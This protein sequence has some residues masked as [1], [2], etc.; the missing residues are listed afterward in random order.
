MALNEKNKKVSKG[1]AGISVMV[2]NASAIVAAAESQPWQGHSGKA[3]GGSKPYDRNVWPDS[4]LTHEKS[5]AARIHAVISFCSWSFFAVVFIFA[6]GLLYKDKKTDQSLPSTAISAANRGQAPA[7]PAYSQPQTQRQPQTPA[8]RGQEWTLD[9]T[10]PPAGDGQRM[11]TRTEITY[12][13]A[14]EIR[15]EAAAKLIDATKSK[16]V[17]IYNSMIADLNDSCGSFRYRKSDMDSATGLVVIF[18]SDL[19]EQGRMIARNI[20][21]LRRARH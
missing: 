14:Q 8:Q 6:V 4:K 17:N 15:M 19:E 16:D 7:N 18:R 10:I 5:S 20:A 13:L 3:G 12:C 21:A 11:L 1:F 2:S 9:E